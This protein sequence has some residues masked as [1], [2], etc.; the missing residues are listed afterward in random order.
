MRHLALLL[1]TA[2]AVVACKK[3]SSDLEA[4]PSKPALALETPAPAAWSDLGTVT[5][6]GRASG[7]SQVTVAGVQATVNGDTFTAPIQLQRGINLVEARGTDA[8]GHALFRRHGV[9]AGT[10]AD[11]GVPIDKAVALRLNRGG[12]DAIL[13]QAAGLLDPEAI[14]QALPAINPVYEDSYAWG[15]ADISIDLGHIWFDTAQ[16]TADPAAGVVSLSVSLPAL[17]VWA[18]V[19]GDVP[20]FDP[21]TVDAWLGAERAEIRG[22]LTVRLENGEIVTD[23]VAPS[24]ELVGFWYDLSFVPWGIE[25]WFDSFVRRSLEDAIV[26]QIDEMVPTLIDEQLAALDL[27]FETDLMGHR[28]GI[29]ADLRT[30]SIDRDGILLVADLDVDLPSAGAHPY[31]GY[32]SAPP[33]TPRPDLQSDIAMALS[34]NLVNRVLFEAWQSG[35]LSMSLSSEEGT[36]EPILLSQL[37]A[38]ESAAVHLDARLPP[39]VVET[40]D[41]GLQAQI[42]ELDV[43]I[44][45]PNGEMGER[46]DLS[47]TARIGLE[48]TLKNGELALK[49]REPD[50]V[51]EVRGSDWGVSNETIT[52]LLVDQLPIQVLL[53]LLGDF[54]FP[55]PE[56]G[57]LSFRDATVGRDDSG[58]YT[59]IEVGLQ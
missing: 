38:R 17:D 8:S 41:G 50:V 48:L 14:N 51:L 30:V 19:T 21:V 53:L 36:L 40:A 10:F 42:G 28:L 32:L 52:N 39:V 6:T 23:L 27:S 7:L 49:L 24:V 26:A 9:I 44:L 3:K 37:G 15:A 22:M 16:I 47:V 54:K 12:L 35:M 45:T 46:L 25:G 13:E 11:P 58:V 55:L 43:T 20:L 34:D 5:A 31:K 56:L 2:A 29:E 59:A 1:A 4:E 57:G 33:G 18:P